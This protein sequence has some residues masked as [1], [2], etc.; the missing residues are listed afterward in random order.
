M[1]DTR[2]DMS[3]ILPTDSYDRI[4]PVIDAIR[5]TA[6]QCR[7]E[8]VV[9]C[10]DGTGCDLGDDVTIVRV[11][12]VYPLAAS[13][14]AGIRQAGGEYVFI[15]ETHSFP[16]SGMFDK[17]LSC[18]TDGATVAVPAFLNA[19]PG[20]LVSWACFINGYAP[21]SAG[22]PGGPLDYAPLFNVS[23]ERAFLLDSGDELSRVLMS[24]EDMAAR[25]KSIGGRM[26]F[27]PRAMIGHVNIAQWQE[28]LTQR[29]VAGRVIASV[30]SASWSPLRRVAYGASFPL[31]PFVLLGRYRR[32]IART[33]RSN[34]VSV[35]LWPLLFTG[36]LFQAAGECLGYVLGRDA[37]SEQRYD[38]YE[39][40][41]IQYA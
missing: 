16:S 5:E 7:L 30:R 31:I 37:R 9:V 1:S 29:V 10:P 24:G 18:H 27:E 20:S 22:R 40:E 4:R 36:M 21:W 34:E 3:I 14:A 17:L 28:W 33:V 8:I 2:Y 25:M 13:R 23:Y 19:N 41:Q 11:R 6:S 12:S 26:A 32:S 15:G 38:T 39:I 35:A